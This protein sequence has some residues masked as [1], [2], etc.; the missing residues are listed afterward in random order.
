MAGG[1]SASAPDASS[2]YSHGL[3]E[4]AQVVAVWQQ[5]NSNG[6]GDPTTGEVTALGAFNGYLYAGTFNPVAPGPDPLFDGAQIFRSSDGVA[7]A[8]VTQPGFMNPHDTA[9]PAILDFTVFKTR[10]YAS[11]GRGNAAQIWRSQDGQNWMPMVAAGFGDPDNVNISALAEYN[12][13]LYAGV[14][15]QVSGAKIYR[16]STGDNAIGSWNPQVVPVVPGTETAGV[17]GL[18][19]FGNALYAAVES[20]APVQIWR[21]DGS[22]WTA[23][24]SNGFSDSPATSTGGMAEFAGYL[25]VG[26]GNA[27]QGA[28]LWRTNNGTNWTQA[29][30]PGSGD[31]NNQKVEMVFVFQNHL[32]VS[33]KNAVTGMELWCSTD[34][35]LWEQANQDGF[36]DSN[37]SGSN[38]G[39][40]AADF[41][42]HLYVGTVNLVNGGELWRMQQV[43]YLYI[44]LALR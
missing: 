24:V 43:A 28:Q 12:G 30:T 1:V 2:A 23:V 17:T 27:V 38:R 32:Y 19:V 29:T 20:D 26:A 36:G 21:F 15:N 11:T 10:L 35:M 34:G 4:L 37:N 41:S 5:V 40:A 25:Y 18:A 3:Y 22:S 31:T 16:S 8:S 6:F 42:G 7:W 9:A 39:N 14:T 13:M 44:P 33:V